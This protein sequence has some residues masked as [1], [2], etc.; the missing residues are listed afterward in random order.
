MINKHIKICASLA[1]MEM[2]IKATV[3]YHVILIQ[4]A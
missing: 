2:Q 1:F 3:R 4:A